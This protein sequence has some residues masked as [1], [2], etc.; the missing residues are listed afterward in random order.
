MSLI[1]AFGDALEGCGGFA[2]V[3]SGTPTRP[4]P[5]RSFSRY[6]GRVVVW[7]AQP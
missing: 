7:P 3:A 2:L 6:R 4:A 1:D 5:G